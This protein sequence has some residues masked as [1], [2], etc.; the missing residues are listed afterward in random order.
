[1]EHADERLRCKSYVNK[2]MMLVFNELIL[3][4]YWPLRMTFN[5]I[6]KKKAKKDCI[7]SKA[8]LALRS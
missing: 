8:M 4:G 3:L 1:M 2:K 7:I 5:A 6:D